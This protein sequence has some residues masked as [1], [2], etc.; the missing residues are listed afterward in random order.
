MK[1]ATVGLCVLSILLA[2]LAALSGCNS[3]PVESLDKS[4]TYKV[5]KN[6]GTSEPIK[7]DFLWVVDN[8]S[9]MC[10]EQ[11]ALAENFKTFTQRLTSQFDID[12]RLAVTTVD[13]QCAV[14][15]TSIFSSQGSFNTVPA[16]TFPPACQESRVRA[17][18]NDD[19]CA[20]MDC[21]IRG[22]CD[23]GQLPPDCTCADE[24]DRWNCRTTNI[25]SCIQT[26]N[27]SINTLCHRGCTTD[28][29]CQELFGDPRYVCQ[30]PSGNQRDWGCL[31]PPATTD[32]PATVPA[33]LD[34]SNL[35][36]FACAATVGV[37]QETSCF[38]YE[39]GLRA[40]MLALDPKGRNAAQAKAFLRDDAYLVLIFVSDEDDCSVADG[41]FINEDDYDTC[42]LLPTTDE[43]G[44]LVPVGH[45]VNRLKALKSDPGKVIVAA[46]AGDSTKTDAASVAADRAAYLSAKAGGRDCFKQSYIC[47]SDQGKADYGSR[48]LQLTESFGPNGSFSNICSAEGIGLALQNIADT[49]IT[50]LNKLCLPRPVLGSLKV[51]RRLPDGS[52][53]EI[54]EGEGPGHYQILRTSEDCAMNGQILPAIAFGDPPTPGEEIE[55]T[56]EGDPQ[57][58]R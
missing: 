2:G 11:V 18:D 48:Y 29:E 4:F 35:D 52:E 55:V 44:P 51:I 22:E 25:A 5:Q 6:S 14:N 57:F 38:K 58:T 32:C 7:I 12:P 9:S 46:I 30:K 16:R 23:S 42:G 34:G 45:Y 54:P 3:V 53:N 39:Q 36:L 17:C 24:L 27:G 10:Q 41:R 40:G 43:G 21:V 13:V 37:N 33:I 28:E 47:L 15:N 49:I 50:V 1:R 56:Y 19:V 26:P 8:S 31:L 20:N